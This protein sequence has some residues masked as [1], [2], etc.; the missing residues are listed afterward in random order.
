MGSGWCVIT[1]AGRVRADKLVLA[2]DGYTDDLWPGLRTSIVPIYSA[3]TASAPLQA[4]IAASVLPGGGVVYESGDLTIYYRRDQANRLLMGGR[5]RQ[6]PMRGRADAAHLVRYAERLWPALAGVEWTHRWNGQFAL[7][8]DFYPRFHTPAPN[9]YIALGY[10]GRG[11]AL[12][13]AVGA[14][15]AAAASGSPVE[16][17]ALP[18]TD[19]VRIPFHTLWKVGVGARVAYS[20]LRNRLGA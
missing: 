8:P 12:G 18:V 9:V 2:T 1:S 5:G 10:S 20:M 17:L 6:R 3:I 19:I 13:T 4:S 16:A 15:L 11:V 14:E 7:T